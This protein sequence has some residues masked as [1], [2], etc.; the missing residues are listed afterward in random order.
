M[1][2]LLHIIILL[3]CKLLGTVIPASFNI[4]NE[5]CFYA[6][7]HLFCMSPTHSSS[8]LES[9]FYLDCCN[10]VYYAVCVTVLFTAIL[11]AVGVALSVTL[12]LLTGSKTSLAAVL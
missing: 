6:Y 7:K 9:Q 12:A 11:R 8:A 2:L 4:L 5:K 3:R 1:L 10:H